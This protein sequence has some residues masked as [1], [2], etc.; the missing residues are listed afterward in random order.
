MGI[1][2]FILK[3]SGDRFFIA[4]YH[5]TVQMY[6]TLCEKS[7]QPLPSKVKLEDAANIVIKFCFINKWKKI[8]VEKRMKHYNYR[9]AVHIFLNSV[10][11]NAL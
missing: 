8:C 10:K 9:K 3:F 7:S 11:K 5:F 1:H 6:R 2:Q 4:S